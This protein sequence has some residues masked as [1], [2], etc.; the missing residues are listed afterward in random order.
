VRILFLHNA[1][2]SANEQG[3]GRAYDFAKQL[4]DEG[5]E[6]VII[7]SQYSYLT[8]ESLVGE[9]PG[10]VFTEKHP[11]G[12]TVLRTWSVSGYHASY[13]KR[14]L[15]FITFMVSSMVT[16]LRVE[17]PDVLVAAS[18]PITVAMIGGLV[19]AMRNL[20]FVFEIRDLW[21]QVAAELGIV[22]NK[23]LIGVVRAW[24]R[25]LLRQARVVVINSP[26]FIEPLVH[27]G[28]E[29]Q[30]I[31]L[32]PNGVDT[33]TFA[34]A[35]DRGAV[36]KE[37]GFDGKFVVTYAGS[38]GL[39]NDLPTVLNTADLLRDDPKVLFVLVG[40]GNRRRQ[41]EADA[42]ERKLTNVRFIGP[43]AKQDVSRYL[44][45]SDGCFVTLLD[46]PLFRT[47]YPNKAFDAM[48]CARPVIL[49][50]DGVIRKCVEDAD[51]G[52]FVRPGDARGFADAI[53]ALRSNPA[54]G[55]EMGLNGRRAVMQSFDRWACA[56]L[57]SD[58]LVK[59]V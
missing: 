24:E 47:V 49:L 35:P 57:M 2:A 5:H 38:L 19:A 28:A 14:V 50:V 44:S 36:R 29:R 16:A 30:K 18:P 4:V 40:D 25:M 52:V 46:T 21:S 43:V 48:A 55:D 51:C 9:H 32:V 31:K 53:I 59:A 6:V 15:G 42:A 58:V 56:R 11:A 26:G 1:F 12:F 7:T 33:A 13:A 37:L 34:P 22:K 54:R 23:A 27:E 3:S 10:W 8:G 41:C 39:A 20:P 17:R 45:A